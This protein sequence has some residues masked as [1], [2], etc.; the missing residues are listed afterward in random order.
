MDTGTGCVHIAPGHGEDD[1]SLGRKHGLPI[2]SPVDDHGRFTDEAGLPDWT[3]KYVFDANADIVALLRE[4]GML[5]AKQ[6]ISIPIRIAGARKRRS[7]SARSSSSSSA[8]TIFA[9][10]PSRRSRM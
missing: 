6:S 4:K 2:L 3:G 1:Y 9:R 10:T 8:S 7:S 5:L